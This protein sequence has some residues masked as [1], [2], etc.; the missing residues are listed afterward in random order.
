MIFVELLKVESTEK[1]RLSMCKTVGIELD[2]EIYSKAFKDILKITSID[3]FRDF[4]YRLLLGKIFTNKQLYKWN[5]TETPMCNICN[6]NVI[7]DVKHLIIE[8]KPSAN[9]WQQLKNDLSNVPDC[10]WN[11]QSIFLNNVH[12]NPLNIVNLLVVMVKQYIFQHKCLNTPLKYSQLTQELN[13]YCKFHY[14]NSKNANTTKKFNK[15]WQPVLHLFPN[16]E[17]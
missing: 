12:D 14:W 9:L 10:K 7:Q 15:R 16:Y 11:P 17:C 1:Y 6:T 3:K 8:C 5:I 2:K 13:F 4:Q